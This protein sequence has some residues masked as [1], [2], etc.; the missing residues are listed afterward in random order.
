[1]KVVVLEDAS[2]PENLNI[3][4]RPDPVANPGEVLVRMKAASLN[5]RDLVMT[6]G[7]YGSR[8]RTSDLIPLSDGAGVVVAL[9]EAAT[10]FKIGDRVTVSFFQNWISGPAS[11]EK[12]N[13]DI[14]RDR[15]GVLCELRAF[16]EQGLAATPDALS[17]VE[18]ASLPCAAL[19]AWSAIAV[20]GHTKPG[21]RIIV[22]GT[23]GVA[24]FALQF[25]KLFGAEVIMTSSSDEKLARAAALGADQ[26]INYR[27]DK[28]WGKTA[29]GLTA[30]RGVDN[31]IELG[32]SDTLRQS[33]WAIRPGGIICLIGVLS[34][35]RAELLIPLIGSRNVNLQG[36]S[37]GTREGLE[38]MMRGMA[39]NGVKPVIDSVYPIEEARAAFGSGVA[40][41][42][43]MPAP[44]EPVKTRP[45][46]AGTTTAWK[47]ELVDPA[48]VPRAY[49]VPN[50]KAI[51]SAIRA[52][53]DQGLTPQ[54]D[55]LRIFSIVG[56]RARG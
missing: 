10:R 12:I 50:D 8:Q 3:V 28:E 48:I 13:S 53:V 29:L 37:V 24:L 46:T 45:T 6:R 25:A 2:G 33:L 42:T 19:T 9:G 15:D 49:L 43:P 56:I 7:G 5:Y 35:A 20:Y 21:D 11:Q 26:L 47:F 30:G 38:D 54:I 17:D 14:G 34:G 22:Q 32:G 39:A 27:S 31:I 51:R 1:M 41:A 44:I 55:G 36:V 40:V 52:M 16:N 23:G 18:A 4:E